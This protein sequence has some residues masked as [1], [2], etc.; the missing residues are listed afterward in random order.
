MTREE[1]FSEIES[2]LS[3]SMDVYKFKNDIK[4][5][6]AW[7]I[8]AEFNRTYDELYV[9]RRA[10][11]LST[12]AAKLIREDS[13]NN[14]ALKAFKVSAEAYEYLGEISEQLDKPFCKILSALC[15]DIAGYQANA[16]CLLVNLINESNGEFYNVVRTEDFNSDLS[17]ENYILKHIQLILLKKI[18]FGFQINRKSEN[19]EACE[20]QIGISLFD[21]AIYN[22]YQ[23]ILR[24]GLNS[25]IA[26]L[27][28]AY[29][30][31]LN[32]GNAFISHLLYLLICRF[33]RYS[34]R[35]IWN[36]LFPPGSS[37]SNIWSKYIRLLANDF[38]KKFKIK[39]PEDRNSIFEF[40]ISQLQAV[41]QGVLTSDQSFVLQ[42]PTSAGK[43]FIAEIAILS[44][45][46]NNEGKK[47]IYVAPFRALTNEKEVELS[48]NL[49]KLGYNVSSLSGSYE[50]DEYQ[51]FIL[52]STDVLIATPEKLDLLYRL[53]PSYFD[54]VSVLVID[55]GHIIGNLD[56]R[57]SLLEFLIIRLK[58]KIE[59][60][61]TLFISAVMPIDDGVSFSK[62]VSRNEDHIISSPSYIDETEWQPTRKIIGKFKWVGETSSTITYNEIN[63][64]EGSNVEAF[65]TNLIKVDKIGRRKFPKKGNKSHAAVALAYKLSDAGNVLVFCSRPDW[66]LSVLK[67]FL[68]LFESL[69]KADE[70]IKEIFSENHES[71]SCYLSIKWLGN[72]HL[73]TKCLKR[74]IGIHYGDLPEPLR[75]AIE[76][77]YKSGVIKVLIST[78]TIGQGLNFPIKNLI[79]HSLDIDPQ[80]GLKVGVRDFW[81]IIGRAGRAGKETEGQIIF[82]SITRSDESKYE[83]Y[84]NKDNFEKVSSLFAIL[85]KLR[86]NSRWVS[87]NLVDIQ[88]SSSRY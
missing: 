32:K 54:A 6:F 66:A 49:S 22:W 56:E 10:L 26:Y 60:L 15:Y 86:L 69:N 53:D 73:I 45:L 42:M 64:E 36:N 72:E 29:L 61:K 71:L 55:E 9:W 16:F 41:Q 82:L 24:G 47:C 46:I 4:Q 65:V 43:T 12:N 30:Y 3:S 18:P 35:S 80:K 21:Q 20:D 37:Y 77:D 67:T 17:D 85:A 44:S 48:H 81:N 74:N 76:Q 25:S 68:Y 38:Y 31:Y 33:D 14:I 28:N 59:N 58:S 62:W 19:P 87:P 83:E 52:E 84:L 2:S 50:I 70:E 57:S 13:E 8:G 40:W 34:K 23:H 79:I 7:R 75:K 27:Q 11:F 88:L 78:N 63:T 5:I 39:D 1:Y 51:N